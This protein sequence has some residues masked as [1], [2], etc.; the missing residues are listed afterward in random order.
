MSKDLMPGYGQTSDKCQ[1]LVYETEDGQ[2][3]V[4]V[5]LEEETVWLT[6]QHMV[7]LFQSSQQNISHHVRCIYEE[8]EL[9]PESTKQK[10]FVGASGGKPGG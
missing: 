6:Q 2:V 5:R 1:F 4:D 8:G 3:K 7:E 9:A 10:I